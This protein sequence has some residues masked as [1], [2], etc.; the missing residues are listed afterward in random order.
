LFV[1]CI[2]DSLIITRFDKHVNRISKKI[3]LFMWNLIGNARTKKI[4]LYIVVGSSITFVFFYI[5]NSYILT[6]SFFFCQI[7][8]K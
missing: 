7:S 4:S 1:A 6:K 8:L 5:L 2:G 3:L